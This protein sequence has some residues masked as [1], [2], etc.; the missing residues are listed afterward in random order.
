MGLASALRKL[1]TT[2]GRIPMATAQPT[3]AH[4]MITNPLRGGGMMQLFATHPPL[5]DRI[6]RLEAMVGHM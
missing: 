3:T 1:E 2:T 5:E 4:M 6:A